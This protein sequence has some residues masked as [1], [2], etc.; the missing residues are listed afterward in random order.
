MITPMDYKSVNLVEDIKKIILYL[1]WD[2]VKIKQLAS[3]IDKAW[4]VWVSTL[5]VINILVI[6]FIN[7]KIDLC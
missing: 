5:V 6:K 7:R 3:F 2:S 4:V 1:S